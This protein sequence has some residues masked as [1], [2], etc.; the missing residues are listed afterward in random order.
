[1]YSVLGTD[2]GASRSK[3]AIVDASG[4]P[5]AVPNIDGELHILSTAYLGEDGRIEVGRP[6]LERGYMAPDRL[7]QN[8]KPKLSSGESLWLGGQQM[9]AVEPT[10]ALVRTLKENGERL[11]NAEINCCVTACPASANDNHKANLRRAHELAGLEVERIIPEPTAA[12]YAYGVQRDSRPSMCIVFDV[13]A[14][15]SDVSVM[16]TERG[17]IKVLACE[18]RTLGGNDFDQLLETHVLDALETACGSRPVPNDDPLFFLDLLQRIEHAKMSL[19]GRTEVPI[20]VAWQGHCHVITLKQESFVEDATSL[21]RQI[22]DTGERVLAAAGLRREDLDHLLVVGGSARSPFVRDA[23]A[24]RVGLA[25]RTD[26]AVD[27]AVAYGVALI[28]LEELKRRGR[29]SS[30]GGRIIPAP[31]VALRDITTHAV[32][33]TVLD[34]ESGKLI[35]TAIIDQHTEI[36][37]RRADEFF[38]EHEDQTHAAVEVLQG[39]ANA[40]RDQ[41][42]SIGTLILADLPKESRRTRRIRVEYA[43]NRDGMVTATATDKVSGKSQTVSLDFRSGLNTKFPET[44]EPVTDEPA[45][46]HAATMHPLHPEACH[47]PSE[48]LVPALDHDSSSAVEARHDT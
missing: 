2:C 25:P 15:T 30:L 47:V 35:N 31:G 46:A 5:I 32:G 44:T 39:D 7:V 36:P 38:L 1:M 16:Q 18:G 19:G 3:C 21:L 8:F 43:I 27:N 34:R 48:I 28:C 13:G 14:Y 4:A 10:A 17:E 11:V 24:R 45:A 20:T 33:C 22:T 29:H 40:E 41:C 12:G 6:A 9:T 26:I 23:I 37:C 42:T